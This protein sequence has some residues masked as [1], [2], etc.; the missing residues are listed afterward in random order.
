[1]FPLWRAYGRRLSANVSRSACQRERPPFRQADRKRQDPP[2]RSRHRTRSCFVGKR[3]IRASTFTPL[4]EPSFIAVRLRRSRTRGG[5]EFE[6]HHDRLAASGNGKTGG[7]SAAADRWASAVLADRGSPPQPHQTAGQMPRSTTRAPRRQP[8][9]PSASG[10]LRGALRFM[11]SREWELCVASSSSWVHHPP[12]A[13][14][15]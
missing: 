10:R 4:A 1:M 12:W 9:A 6:Y 3:P 7:A 14:T 5:V 2:T 11:C 15:G 13:S 8:R